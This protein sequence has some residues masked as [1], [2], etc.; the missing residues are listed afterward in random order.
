MRMIRKAAVLGSG[1]MGSQIAALLASAGIPVHLLDIVPTDLKPGD[2]RS[3]LAE[4]AI[5]KLKKMTPSP[6]MHP[7]ALSMITPGN[8]ED[9]LQR[10]GEVD[11]VLEAVVE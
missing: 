10:V 8:L 9:D 5:G 4:D 3:K 1:V 11:W 2:S 7:R 6:V